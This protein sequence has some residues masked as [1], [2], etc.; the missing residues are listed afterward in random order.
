M[1]EEPKLRKRLKKL[2]S[3]VLPSNELIHVCN[4]Y[5]VVGDVAILPLA[6]VSQR[7]SRV[8]AE[9]IMSIHKNVETVLVQIGPVNGDFR[10]RRLEY[11]VG[12][13]KTA[14]VHKESGCTFHVDVEKCYF[15]PRLFYE[16][17]R[18]AELV[19]NGEIVVN[20]FAGAGCF[21]IVIA[22]HSNVKIVYSIDVNPVAV[23]F[24]RENVRVNR[25]YGKV[26]P[27][28]GD[29]KEII[30]KRLNNIANRVLMPLPE[31][32]FEYLPYALLSLKKTGGWI[33]YYD[34]EHA[35][36]N[37]NPVEK[38]ARKV[39]D[40]LEGLGVDFQVSFGRVVRTTGPNW[41]QV[42]LD[43]AVQQ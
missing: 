3:G 13:N 17:K 6:D 24:L 39:T 43:I 7:H 40:K 20:M 41:Y 38:T 14:T 42:V 30:K 10:L 26:V 35:N 19:K 28:L 4:S 32:A 25:V 9:V 33:H 16:R 12:E 31:K 37:E 5:D 34:F 15:S 29:A 27:I 11:V 21:S 36:K 23:Q 1:M 22:K 8:I 2:L 18:I